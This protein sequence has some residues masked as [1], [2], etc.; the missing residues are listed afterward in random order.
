MRTFYPTHTRVCSSLGLS[1]RYDRRVSCV[2]PGKTFSPHIV[3]LLGVPT[4]SSLCSTPPPSWTPSPRDADWNQ[5]DPLWAARHPAAGFEGNF[6]I[7]VSSEHT[8]INFPFRKDSFNLENDLTN[9]VAAS[10]DFDHLPQRFVA[11]NSQHSAASTVPTLLNSGS[12]RSTGDLVRGN[13]SIAGSFFSTGDLVRGKSHVLKNL[14]SKGEEVTSQTVCEFRRT[15]KISINTWN[16][17][18]NLPFEG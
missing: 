13:D 17:K 7:D 8:P 2:H 10:D 15:S 9:T 12:V 18:L 14:C 3:F 4:L 1:S 11:S 6:S 16:G 5:T